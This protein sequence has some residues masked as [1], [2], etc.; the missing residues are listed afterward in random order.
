MRAAPSTRAGIAGL[1]SMF[2]MNDAVTAAIMIEPASAVPSDAPR[3]VIVFWTPPTSGLSSSGT[4][5]TVTAPS[6]EASAPMPSPTSSIGTRTISGPRP[7]SSAAEQH[8]RARE[9]REQPGATIN[10]GETFGSRRGIP[11]ARDQQ[12]D[13]E[14]QQPRA[15]RE[16]REAEADGEVERHDEEEPGLDEVL[17]EEHGQP[18]AQL[19]VAQEARADERLLPWSSR[20]T[21]QREKSQSTKTPTRISQSV[22][23]SSPRGRVRLRLDPAPLARAQHAE[24][25]RAEPGRREDG[26]D[27][28]E[29]RPR[30]R[31]RVGDAPRE[32]EDRERRSR[33]RRRRP[34]ARRSRSC[35]SRRPAARRRRRSRRRRRPSR[36]RPAAARW[37]SSRR[38]ARRSPA[39]SAPR[40]RPRGT[41]SRRAARAGSCAID[42]VNEPQP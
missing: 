7:A 41:T 42:V 9:Q 32:H 3:F 16:R 20:R 36:R 35:R 39:G 18:A 34:S 40:R 27:D 8:D 33:P 28:V 23:E 12:R 4:A 19:P 29:L 22:G 26:A 37:R 10:R 5:E 1:C 21:C 17:E 24:D 15:G 30:L 38:R 2:A 13:R 14:R 6:C 11:I 25:E 31:R